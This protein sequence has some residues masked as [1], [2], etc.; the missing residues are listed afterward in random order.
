MRTFCTYFDHNYLSQ[1]LALLDSLDRHAGKFELW[2]LALTQECEAVLRK[3]GHPA[4]KVVPV[5]ELVRLNPNLRP[6]RKTRNQAE[7]YFTASPTWFRHVLENAGPGNFVT[8]IDADCYFFT[9]PKDIYEFERES[10][11]TITPHYRRSGGNELYG[12]FNVGWV[13]IRN[14]EIGMSCVHK[15]ADQCIDWCFDIPDGK[16][17]ADQKYLDQWPKQYPNLSILNHSGVNLAYWNVKNTKLSVQNGIVMADKKPL[18]FYHFS[19]LKRIEKNVYDTGLAERKIKIDNVLFKN[20]FLPYC[21]ILNKKK[22]Y[23]T[24]IQNLSNIRYKSRNKQMSK[25]LILKRVLQRKYIFIWPQL[26]FAV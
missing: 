8:K 10:S 11:I 9:S 2:I 19:G 12:K 26:N 6:A 18:C 20:I 1:G 7:F 23:M 22:S 16:R 4:V 24:K 3:I 15:W 5:E 14:D 17:Y 25:V 13:T 21:K